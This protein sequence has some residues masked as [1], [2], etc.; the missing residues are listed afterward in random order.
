MLFRSMFSMLSADKE[1]QEDEFK[2]IIK[3]LASFIEKDK[4][5]KQLAAKLAA[6]LQRCEN[7]RQWND[8]AYALSLLQH[9]DESITKTIQEG[10][11][12][13]QVEA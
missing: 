10:F 11:K 1:L 3:F 7:E 5:A 13:V 6:R 2:R 8:V 4:H 9:K 12:V